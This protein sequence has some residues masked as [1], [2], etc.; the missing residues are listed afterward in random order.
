MDK[1]GK[2]VEAQL[3]IA[4]LI[5]E[6]AQEAV[7]DYDSEVSALENVAGEDMAISKLEELGKSNA[8]E[9][10]FG[11]LR[12]LINYEPEYG[13]AVAAIG[14]EWLN[15]VIVRDVPSL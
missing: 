10:Y 11:P 1:I 9:G 14:K 13:Q 12:S 8:L 3:N 6:K 2:R 7:R 5:L 15:A 4:L